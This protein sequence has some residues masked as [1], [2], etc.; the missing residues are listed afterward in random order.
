M[1]KDDWNLRFP[2]VELDRYKEISC[3]RSGLN[4]NII[5]ERSLHRPAHA[6]RAMCKFQKKRSIGSF[7]K[8]GYGEHWHCASC[9]AYGS[10]TRRMGAGDRRQAGAI[11]QFKESDEASCVDPC[12]RRIGPRNTLTWNEGSAPGI[13]ARHDVRSW[14]SPPE[15]GLSAKDR[16]QSASHART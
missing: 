6:T 8:A 4:D 7:N 10:C 16:R 5:Q 11:F 2:A 15:P 1:P 3:G 13:K 14:V 9:R 12:T